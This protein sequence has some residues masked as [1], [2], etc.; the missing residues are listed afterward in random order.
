M[1]QIYELK[2]AGYSAR[3]IAREF[4]AGPQYGVAVHEVAGGDTAQAT[5]AAG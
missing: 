4:G 5:A 1:K 3:A 2:G